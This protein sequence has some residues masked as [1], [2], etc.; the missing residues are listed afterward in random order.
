MNNRFSFSNPVVRFLSFI[1]L[2]AGLWLLGKTFNV[3]VVQI[4][5]WLLQYPLWLS[6]LFFVALYVGITTVLWF[7]TID[8]FRTTAAILF[9]PYLSTILVYIAEVCNAS[10]LFSISRKLGREFVEQRFHLKEKDLRYT[11]NTAGFWWAFALRI[12][13][14]VPLRFLDLGFGL[15]KLPFFIFVLSVVA[16]LPLRIFWLQLI[17]AGVGDAVFKDQW[18]MVNYLLTHQHILLFSGFYFMAVVII[19]I[20]AIIAS[21]IGR[22][23]ERKLKP[24]S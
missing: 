11:Q 17:L 21:A 16:G 23:G 10:I 4:R 8:I 13:P 6:G 22:R 24:V 7:G 2:L 15:T 12:N 3:D 14:L 9:G 20:V 18:M 1:I 19:T 5:T